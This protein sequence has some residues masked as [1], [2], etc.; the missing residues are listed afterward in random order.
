[1]SARKGKRVGSP[2]AAPKPRNV[3]AEGRE[4]TRRAVTELAGKALLQ[5]GVAGLSMRRVSELAG[6]STMVLYTL[7]GGKDG[8]TEAVLTDSFVQLRVTITEAHHP[9]HP[10]ERVVSMCQTYRTFALAHPGHYAL[11]FGQAS[12]GSTLSAGS[13]EAAWNSLAPLLET[14]R[15]VSSAADDLG[16]QLWLATHGL[17]SAELAGY[18]GPSSDPEKGKAG[19]QVLD[20]MVRGLLSAHIR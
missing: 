3:R 6:T 8:L 9:E 5:E 10:A 14:L 7:F 4:A 18:F 19:E 20:R 1:M 16:L 12:P 11:M 17:V 13:K 2:Q 15:E